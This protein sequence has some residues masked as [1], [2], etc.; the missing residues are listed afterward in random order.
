M[1]AQSPASAASSDA[2]RLKRARQVARQALRHYDLPRVRLK[3]IAQ[4][5]NFVYRVHHDGQPRYVLRLQN[6]LLSDEQARLQLQWMSHLRA[7]AALPIPEPIPTIDGNPFYRVQHPDLGG[8]RRAVLLTWLNGDYARPVTPHHM[9]SLGNLLAQLHQHSQ[10][11][12]VSPDTSCHR[13]D[14]DFLFGKTFCASSPSAALSANQ[15][16]TL[17]HARTRIEALMNALAQHPNHFGLIHGDTNANNVIYHDGDARL[18][19]FDEFGLGY[20]LYDLA[21]ALRL[22]T[23]HENFPLLRDALIAS[24]TTARPSFAISASALDAM[25]AATFISYLNFGFGLADQTNFRR[26]IDFAVQQIARFST[27]CD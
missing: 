6:A 25:L 13:L 8:I 11:F 24:Y 3:L 15:R 14:A 17:K 18:I 20:Y 5:H 26:W 23:R 22:F 16:R 9:E 21:E 27:S 12:A 7:T 10:S 1:S 2:L 19:D 4:Q